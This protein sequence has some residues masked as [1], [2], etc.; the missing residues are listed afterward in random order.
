[1]IQGIRKAHPKGTHHTMYPHYIPRTIPVSKSKKPHPCQP[2]WGYITAQ[3][4]KP[5]GPHLVPNPTSSPT[6]FPS[7]VLLFLPSFLLGQETLLPGGLNQPSCHHLPLPTTLPSGSTSSLARSTHKAWVTLGLLVRIGKKWA[8]KEKAKRQLSCTS[9]VHQL[10]A[11]PP[12]SQATPAQREGNSEGSREKGVPRPL[13]RGKM[14]P[15][16]RSQP[17]A[18]SANIGQTGSSR[19]RGGAARSTEE[20]LPSRKTS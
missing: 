7:P 6:Q 20:R 14:A 9:H 1:M 2:P 8:Q 12:P 17:R 5:P 11:P 18:P 3:N 4:L 16:R 19:G 10:P 13:R 15:D